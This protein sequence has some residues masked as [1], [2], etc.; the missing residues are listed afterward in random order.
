MT[1]GACFLPFTRA[2]WTVTVTEHVPVFFFVETLEPDFAQILEDF[3]AVATETFTVAFFGTEIESNVA[4]DFAEYFL[5]FLT[6]TDLTVDTFAETLAAELS[7]AGATELS[8]AGAVLVCGAATG[9]TAELELDVELDPKLVA[10]VTVKL[11][12][13]PLV[14]PVTVHEV[15]ELEHV[16]PLGV[17][18]AV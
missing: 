1:C 11:Y 13:V 10:A 15:V 12:A 17:D 9:V 16:N 6:F 8:V 2:G 18:V 7:V 14:K 5:F 3:D 4:T